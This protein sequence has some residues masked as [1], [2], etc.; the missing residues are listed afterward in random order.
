MNKQ[1]IILFF[2][3]LLVFTAVQAQEDGKETKLRKKYINLSFTNMKMTQDD[4]PELK[5]NYGVAFSV[6]RTFYLHKEPIANMIRFGIDATW[7]DMNYTNYKIEYITNL[8]TEKYEY[9]QGEISMHI[10]PSITINPVD[11]LDIHGY[12]RYAPTFSGLYTD[13]AFYG[14]YASFFVGGGSI[15]YGVIGLGIE[16]QFG[17]CDY[18]EFVSNNDDEVSSKLKMKLSGWR[19]YLTFKF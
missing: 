12:F 7:F 3:F 5:S 1:K 16:S 18:K 13:D 14:N 4:F 17:N 2:A 6:G 10:G 19:A 9:Y 8:D 11:K 15:S